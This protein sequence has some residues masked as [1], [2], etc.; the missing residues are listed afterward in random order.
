MTHQ[1]NRPECGVNAKAVNRAQQKGEDVRPQIKIALHVAW[2][3]TLLIES[4]LDVAARDA[5]PKLNIRTSC[6]SAARRLVFVDSSKE[7]CIKHEMQA[8][9]VL[10]RHWSQYAKVDKTSCVSKVTQGGPPSY[11][12]LVSCL[13]TMQHARAIRKSL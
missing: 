2:A 12:E 8:H 13:D 6:E 11:S 3:V 10:V 9:E 5:V 7:A 4:S 1:Q